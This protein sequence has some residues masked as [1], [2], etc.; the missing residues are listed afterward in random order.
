MLIPTPFAA[1]VAVRRQDA[2][3][4]P[5]AFFRLACTSVEEELHFVAACVVRWTG[6]DEQFSRP[7][8]GL[9]GAW[10]ETDGGS[11]LVGMAG[12]MRDPYL[13]D[14]H[15]ARLRHVYV[16]PPH[17]GHGLAEALVRACLAQA[18]GHFRIMR[19]NA[20]ADNAARLYTRVGFQPVN[21]GQRATHIL[22]L[23]DV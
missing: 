13:D 5:M 22:K 6:R 11:E 18:Q 7:G 23:A 8:E 14:P 1:S 16:A 2:G 17:R 21:D 10:I 3:P 12:V 20:I 19:L 4:L 9:F 15:I